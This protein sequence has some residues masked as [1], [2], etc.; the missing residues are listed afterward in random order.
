MEVILSRLHAY[1]VYLEAAA[2][3]IEP[4]RKGRNLANA[5]HVPD[6]LKELTGTRWPL[7]SA[8]TQPHRFG[9]SAPR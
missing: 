7:L 8:A 5:E 2:L 4:E 6:Q 3:T 9:V 1:R